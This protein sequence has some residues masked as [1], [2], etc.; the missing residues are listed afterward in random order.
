M[1]LTR[2]LLILSLQR[3]PR[4]SPEDYVYVLGNR[5]LLQNLINFLVKDSSAESERV[6]LALLTALLVNAA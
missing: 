5:S 4:I 3:G 2:T 1:I 6:C